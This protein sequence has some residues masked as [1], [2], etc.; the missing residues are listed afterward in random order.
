S[1]WRTTNGPSHPPPDPTTAPQPPLPRPHHPSSDLHP[2]GTRR[3]P[4][5]SENAVGSTPPSRPYP[6]VQCGKTFVR[7]THLKTHQRTHTG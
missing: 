3:D 4:A 5:A 2:G 1:P 7:L 6:C